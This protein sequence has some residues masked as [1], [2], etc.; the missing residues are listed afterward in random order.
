MTIGTVANLRKEEIRM[1]YKRYLIPMVLVFFLLYPMAVTAST[2]G[3]D[4]AGY[5]YETGTIADWDDLKLGSWSGT[6]LNKGTTPSTYSLIRE[7]IGLNIGFTFNFYGTNSRTVYLSRNGF[8][9]FNGGKE[10]AFD[11]LDRGAQPIPTP[12]GTV[13]NFIAGLWANLLTGA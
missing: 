1:K 7:R 5:T 3:P 2:G 10:P 11:F 6:T 8:L 12:G 9:S 13:D 4:R